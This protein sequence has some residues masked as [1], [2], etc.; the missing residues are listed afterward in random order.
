MSCTSTS[1]TWPRC[2]T[3]P[4]TSTND[5]YLIKQIGGT[6]QSAT[7]Q[8]TAFG[9][10]DT[11]QNVTGITGDWSGQ[12]G[13]ANQTDPS[14]G[15]T[16]NTCQDTIIVDPSVLVPLNLKGSPGDDVIEYEGN[17]DATQIWGEGG[18][19]QIFATGPS[20]VTIYGD[21]PGVVSTGQNIINHSGTGTARITPG[22][23]GDDITVDSPTDLV[24]AAAGNNIINGVAQEID[25]GNGINTI[26]LSPQGSPVIVEQHR[27]R[28]GH[29]QLHR[30]VGDGDDQR[31]R[32]RHQRLLARLRRARWP[33]G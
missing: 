29:A 7:I 23:G 15:T 19:N 3:S 10:T 11:Y 6:A 17:N 2:A 33:R 26:N 21:A 12:Q 25:T 16:F 32:H 1:A 28:A 5:T 18:N 27:E 14:D 30:P 9:R 20:A 13:C 8:V 4:A 24:F 22:G 31:H